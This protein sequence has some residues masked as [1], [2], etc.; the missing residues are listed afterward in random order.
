[1]TIKVLIVDPDISFAVPIKRALELSGDFDVRVFASGQ[2]AIEHIQRESQD[3]VVVDFAIDDMP[4]TEVIAGLR[5]FQPGV[6]VLTSPRTTADV[7]QLATLDVQGTI[8]KPYLARQLTPV[9]HEALAARAKLDSK[10]GDVE[11]H[12]EP[13]PTAILEPTITEEPAIQPDDTF[14]RMVDKM[15]GPSADDTPVKP[16]PAINA[17]QGS[18]G[19]IIDEP[20][21]PE[22]ATIGQLMTGQIPP[23]SPDA[24]TPV[25][26]QSATIPDEPSDDLLDTTK[27]LTVLAAVSDDT[28]PIAYLTSPAFIAQIEQEEEDTPASKRF[29]G[30][31]P[32]VLRRETQTAPQ[33]DP[34]SNQPDQPEQAE[35]TDE[36]SS[37]VAAIPE[38]ESS[39]QASQ[40][41]SEVPADIESVSDEAPTQ[42]TAHLSPSRSTSIV[43][44]KFGGPPPPNDEAGVLVYAAEQL[45]REGKGPEAATKYVAAADVYLS[46]REYDE[47]ITY[48]QRAAILT[49]RSLQVH[50]RLAQAFERLEQTQNAVIEYLTIAVNFHHTGDM[51]RALTAVDHALRLDPGNEDAVALRTALG[52][53]APLPDLPTIVTEAP[54]LS[55]AEE[56]SAEPEAP[57]EKVPAFFESPEF[58]LPVY[59]GN[60][61]TEPSD[62]SVLIEPPDAEHYIE[63]TFAEEVPEH[64]PEITPVDESEAEEPP[65]EII[66]PP[67]VQPVSDEPL[68]TLAAQLTQLTVGSS[69]EATL[70]TRGTELVAVAGQFAPRAVS[71]LVELINAAWHGNEQE[72]N[73]ER[74]GGTLVRFIHLEDAGDYLLYSTPT[75]DDMA[76]SMLFPADTPLKLI[77][78]QARD[79][80]KALDSIPDPSG[81]AEAATESPA[82]ITLPSRPTVLRPPEGLRETQELQQTTQE[83]PPEPEAPRT[84]GG[85]LVGYTFVWLPRI[86]AIAPELSGVL[87]DWINAIATQHGWQVDGVEIQPTFVSVQIS[88]TATETPTATVEALMHETGAKADDYALWADAYYIVPSGRTVTQQEIASFIEYQS[89]ASM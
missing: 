5:R 59:S 46:R 45:E 9:I 67:E 14:F 21:L 47:A 61:P 51:T 3:V 49:P 87:L 62:P 80:I 18:A 53:D 63:D 71:G 32:A 40:S 20:E 4:L 75:T 79:L 48:W 39:N 81:S 54:P 83:T 73:A 29:T 68:A 15:Y 84:E 12:G 36:S 13:P 89:Q 10:L 86:N 30:V 85:P 42:P 28:I 52:T 22:D 35:L 77:R 25:H 69:A 82:A 33:V 78:R 88:I 6:F 38:P 7:A 57:V 27:P 74:S 34:F 23:V 44:R 26:A 19:P 43:E 60:E 2:A 76:L 72:G 37:D 50:L 11:D 31:M 66:N 1:M 41:E 24:D 8:T 65:V 70:V 17:D 16:A 56:F 55:I 58:D 64:E